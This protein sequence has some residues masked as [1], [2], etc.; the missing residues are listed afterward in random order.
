MS[1]KC[2]SCGVDYT[3]HLG[4]QGTCA[5]LQSLRQQLAAANAEKKLDDDFLAF[6]E[7]TARTLFPNMPYDGGYKAVMA[8][9][10]EIERLRKIEAAAVEAA[11]AIK[12]HRRLFLADDDDVENALVRQERAV[13]NLISLASDGGK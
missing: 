4:L 11:K 1:D 5:A 13:E 9:A 12:A 3:D 10:S 7:R 8:M 2:E 6:I